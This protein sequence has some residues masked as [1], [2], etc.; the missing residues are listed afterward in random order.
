MLNSRSLLLA[1]FMLIFAAGINLFMERDQ[2]EEQQPENLSRNDPDLYMRN[3]TITQFTK[4][5]VKQHRINAARFTHFPL[6]DITTLKQPDMTLY[7]TEPG[8]NP[9]DVIAKNGRVLPKVL[10]RDEVIEL[11]DDVLAIQSDPEGNFINIRTDSLTIYPATDYAE[12]DQKVII[13]D[14]SGRTTAAGM[15]AYFEEGRFIFFS[16][17][18]ERVKTILL[19]E[20]EKSAD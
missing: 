19:P 10:F 6:T 3:A 18:D 13:D 8:E 16:R 15:K 9:W 5:G 7:A 14:N 1:G 2:A 4:S 20:F 11:W 12:T 17:N